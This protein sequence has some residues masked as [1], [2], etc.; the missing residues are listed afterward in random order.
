MDT[1]ENAT[2][3]ERVYN[4]IFE[5]VKYLEE[6]NTLLRKQLE[7]YRKLDTILN[8]EFKSFQESFQELQNSSQHITNI[9][10]TD[11]FILFEKE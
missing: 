9:C 8:N 1:Q 4:D 10:E 6:Q 11:E 7:N 2:T 3:K 5:H